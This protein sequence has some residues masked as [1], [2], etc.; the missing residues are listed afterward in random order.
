[1]SSKQLLRMVLVFLALIALWGAAALGRRH[2]GKPA[3]GDSFRLPPIPRASV[4]TIAIVRRGDT[5]TLARKDTST[6]TVNGFRAAPQEVKDLLAALADSTVNGDLVAERQTSQAALGVDSAAG[7]RIR[8]MAG[9]RTLADLVA[10]NRSPDFSGGYVRLATQERTYLLPGRLVEMLTRPSVEWRDHRIAAV[11]GD[12]IGAIE[13]S[14][15]ARRYTLRRA[16]AGW[17]LSP[18]GA[19]DS[20]AV[21]G[22]LEAYHTIQAGGFA[23]AAQADSARFSPPDRKARVLRKD[24]TSI[25]TLLFDSTAAGR[26]WVK[27]DTGKTVYLMDGFEADR[28]APADTSLRAKPASARR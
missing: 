20:S 23:S 18:G 1:M 28:L 11:P 22:L 12:S 5:A 2:T 10:G 8:I 9:G 21:A 17:S 13:V 14:R 15:G 16:G 4:D 26:M 27:S 19:A 6:W 3:A 24:A 7:T 25:L